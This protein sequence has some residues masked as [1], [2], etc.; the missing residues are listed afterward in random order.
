MRKLFL[1][2][3]LLLLFCTQSI[4]GTDEKEGGTPAHIIDLTAEGLFVR[5]EQLL[6]IK[7]VIG[8][9]TE[10]GKK[11]VEV[12]FIEELVFDE[13]SLNLVPV[14]VYKLPNEQMDLVFVVSKK[15]EEPRTGKEILIK[16]KEKNE[17][18]IKNILNAYKVEL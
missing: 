4:A 2:P 7:K 9:L 14:K 17:F 12:K 5:S 10:Q 3:L 11:V 6:T 8:I 18:L 13:A 1:L 15:E 16:K